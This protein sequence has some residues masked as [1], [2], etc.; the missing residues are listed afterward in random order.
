MWLSLKILNIFA[1]CINLFFV[2]KYLHIYQLKDYNH[3]RYL[4]FFYKL[5]FIFL[6]ANFLLIV[7]L[8]LTSNFIAKLILSVAIIILNFVFNFNLIKKNKTPIKF[9]NKLKRLYFISSL[10]LVLTL[11]LSKILLISQ[12]LIV[13]SPVLSNFLNFYDKLKNLHFIKAAQKKLKSSKTKVIAITGSNGKTSVKNILFSML[14]TQYKV[15]AT[16]ASYNT[17]LGISKFINNELKSDCNFVILE[18]GARHRNDIKNLCK[19]FGADFGIVT[20]ISPQHLQSFKTI[21]NVVKAKNELPKFLNN[22]LCIF[23]FDNKYCKQMFKENSGKKISISI[24]KKCDFFA[25]DIKIKNFKTEFKLHTKKFCSKITT[26]LLGTHN[27][28]NILLASALAIK[29]NIK[30]ENIVEAISNLKP[31]PHRLEYLKSHINILDDSYN[32]SLPSAKEAINVLTSTEHK[33][34]IVTPGIIEGGKNQF[35][36]NFKLGKMCKNLDYVVIVGNTNKKAIL[37]GIKSQNY[38]CKIFTCKSLDESKRYFKLLNS[39]DCLLLLNDLPDDY[40]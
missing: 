28:T 8:N 15:Q 12:I 33:K 26:N 11:F 16:P 3:V 29:L 20:T 5:K 21:E 25:S 10:L 32:C 1:C 4:K 7:L 34:M 23:N 9:T 13:F 14:K 6:V 37:Y 19:I 40:N 38:K 39:N 22:K 31:T 27:V 35:E 2:E 30:P 17:P 24:A 36:L 18:Y